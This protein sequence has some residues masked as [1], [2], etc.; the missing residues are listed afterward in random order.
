LRK[1]K[2]RKKKR[3][4]TRKGHWEQGRGGTWGGEAGQKKN[5]RIEGKRGHGPSPAGRAEVQTRWTSTENKSAQK[6]QWRNDLPQG[7]P[8]RVSERSAERS[9]SEGVDGGTWPQGTLQTASGGARSIEGSR[10]KA[11]MER[12]ESYKT[13]GSSGKGGFSNILTEKKGGN[14]KSP[15]EKCLSRGAS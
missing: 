6:G 10:K 4:A 14:I 15:R 7:K 2:K 1:S 12:R 11:S 9:T 5:S 8:Y 13:K 3:R